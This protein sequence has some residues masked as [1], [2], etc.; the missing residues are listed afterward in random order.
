MYGDTFTGFTDSGYVSED[1]LTMSLSKSFEQIKEW[2]G[3]IVKRILS[4]FDG[5]LKYTHL[6]VSDFSLKDVFGDAQVAATAATQTHGTQYKVSV[7]G[8]DLPTKRYIFKMK[9]GDARVR[10]LIPVG[11]VTDL[12]DI[13][14]VKNDAIKLGVTLGCQPDEKGNSVYIYTDDGVKTTG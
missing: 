7:G 3:A 6:E 2:G 9:D 8:V 1:G 11:V 4:E 10:L 5:T 13:A 14:F 12:E